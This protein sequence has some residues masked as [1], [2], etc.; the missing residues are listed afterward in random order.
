VTT[1]LAKSRHRQVR[2]RV[3]DAE[4]KVLGR[5]AARAARALMG[6]DSPDWT[7]HADH[8]EGLIIINAEK[9]RLTGR[10]LDDKLY[11]HYTGYPGGLRATTAREVLARKPERLLTEAIRG[12]LPKSRLGDRL[13]TRLR[14]YAGGN[15]P[16]L[17]QRP[18]ALDPARV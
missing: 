11:R 12:M 14:I 1:Y 18:E 7:P 13:A 3:I 8:R 4:G 10:K 5:L 16:H 15:T 6:K 2:W 9:V 17:A